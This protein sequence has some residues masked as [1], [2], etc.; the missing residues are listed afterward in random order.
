VPEHAEPPVRHPAVPSREPAQRW[1]LVVRRDAL[2]ADQGQKEQ[3]AAWEAALRGSGLPLAGLDAENGR[4]RFAVA[5]PLSPAIPGDAELADLWLVERRARWSVRAALEGSLP[6]GSTLV[7]LYDV[8][9]GEPALPGQVVASAYRARLS[10]PAVDPAA[11]EAAAAAV[12]AA[13]E[14]RRERQRGE[15]TVA[16]DLRPFI[17]TVAVEPGPGGLIDVIMVLR[18][19]PEKGIGRPDEVLAELGERSGA[20]LA[21]ASVVRTGLILSERSPETPRSAA[22]PPQPRRGQLASGPV[23]ARPRR[24]AP[25]RSP[26]PDPR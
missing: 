4:P 15:R 20:S 14:L 5:A 10:G 17:E 23:E 1:R 18:H 21:D 2:D 7:D 13:P 25:G 16:Y 22:R 11:I 12:T 26:A 9:L 3:L 8:W 24:D 19:D 6:V